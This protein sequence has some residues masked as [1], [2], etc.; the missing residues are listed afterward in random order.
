[1]NAA[2]RGRYVIHIDDDDEIAD[3]YVHRIRSA[4]Y[5]TPDCV[6]FRVGRWKDGVRVG[7]A[8]H[9]LKYDRYGDH[10]GSDGEK[11]YTRP[12]NHLC[13][14]RTDIA[15]LV[16]FRPVDMEDIDWALRLR[17]LLRREVFIDDELYQYRYVSPERR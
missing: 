10:W 17:P 6:C 3:D 9:S 5:A 14:I 13:A 11:V 16:G 7:H 4:L 1:M 2:A 12:P 8:I 15:R